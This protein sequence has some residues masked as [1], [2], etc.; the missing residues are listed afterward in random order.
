MTQHASHKAETGGDIG[1]TTSAFIRDVSERI[2]RYRR[3]IRAGQEI[4]RLLRMSD[5]QLAALGLRR[6]ELGRQVLKRH[7]VDLDA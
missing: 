7:N 6:S 2:D 5:A 4:E 1:R 3:F